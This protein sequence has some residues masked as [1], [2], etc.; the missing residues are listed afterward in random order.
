MGSTTLF[1][2]MNLL[3]CLEKLINYLFIN[4]GTVLNIAKWQ[5]NRTTNTTMT[6]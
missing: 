1:M 4:F 2:F 3:M 6:L 5:G